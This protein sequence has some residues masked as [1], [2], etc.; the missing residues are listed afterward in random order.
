MTQIKRLINSAK[1]TQRKTPRLF[2]WSHRKRK[3]GLLLAS[4]IFPL[5]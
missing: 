3:V 5:L 4:E 2:W 1:K